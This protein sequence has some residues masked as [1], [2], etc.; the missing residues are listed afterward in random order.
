MGKIFVLSFMLLMLTTLI[1]EKCISAPVIS[2]ESVVSGTVSE[3][4]IVSSHLI[5]IEPEQVI[6]RLTIKIESTE[7]INN[8]PN[9][10]VSKNGQTVQFHS[11]ERLSS[12]LFGKRIKAIATYIGDERGG[13]FWINNIEI[14]K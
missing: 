12:E 7:N 6:Y 14:I 10:L 13:L 4:S 2:N 5:G 3:Y 9:L 1:R 11:K 8:K